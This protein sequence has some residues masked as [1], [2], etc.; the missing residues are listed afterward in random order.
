MVEK[1]ERRDQSRKPTLN[2][3]NE[4]SK[5][6]SGE[7]GP[8]RTGAEPVLIVEEYHIQSSGSRD[9]H[10]GKDMALVQGNEGSRTKRLSF[11]EPI[12]AFE[13]VYPRGNCGGVML[14]TQIPLMPDDWYMW[15]FLG[16]LKE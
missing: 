4:T 13:N 5:K 1:R 16:R 6:V 14:A 12:F 3:H 15:L 9:Q 2:P 10:R 11:R 7:I 8:G